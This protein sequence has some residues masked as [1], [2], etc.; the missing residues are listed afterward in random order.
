MER[1]NP[2]ET[3][4]TLS[5]KVDYEVDDRQIV[6]V[7]IKQDHWIQ[8]IMRKLRLRIPQVRRLKLDEYGSFIF[9]CIDGKRTVGD[10]GECMR[11]RF[12]EQANPLHERLLMFL[13]HIEKSLHLIERTA[14]Q[15]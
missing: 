13:D 14:A 8:R 2:L 11:E 10:I 1:N 3:V 12:G 5:A 7:L 9:L 15:P 4:Y 6:T